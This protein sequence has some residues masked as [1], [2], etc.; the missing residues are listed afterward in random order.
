[1]GKVLGVHG[2]KLVSYQ[3]QQ[4]PQEGGRPCQMIYS[5]VPREIINNEQSRINTVEVE[6][7]QRELKYR[8]SSGNDGVTNE[9]LQ[10]RGKA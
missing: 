8:K 4:V 1:M 6:D 7:A 2:E 10:Y 5:G 9:I 3:W